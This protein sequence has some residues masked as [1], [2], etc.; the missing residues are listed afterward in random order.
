MPESS[1]C[2]PKCAESMEKG[3]IADLAH[4]STRQSAWTPG[5]PLPR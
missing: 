4:G 5:D 2:C 3:Y 1:L